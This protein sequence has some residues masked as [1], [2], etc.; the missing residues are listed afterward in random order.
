[1]VDSKKLAVFVT[2][3]LAMAL[4][5]CS[6]EK[7]NRPYVFM[8]GDFLSAEELPYDSPPQII[9]R[10]DDHRFVTLE[11][12]RDCYHG[13]TWYNDTSTGIRK[14]LGR[15]GIEAYQ[16]KLINADPT[17]RNLAFPSAAPP[18]MASIDRG[19]TVGLLYST[20]GG[21]TFNSTS[22]MDNSFDP[23]ADS[24]R[25][26]IIADKNKLY[27][28]KADGDDEAYVVEKPL[29]SD[30]DLNKPYPPG[31]T[32]DSF[33]LSEQPEF[34]TRFRTPSGQ[35]RITCDSSVKPTNP[36]APLG[37]GGP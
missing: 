17:G 6:G 35:D 33:L 16:G 2:A 18:H 13:D 24:K 14:A 20:D 3:F 32:G 11:R 15:G 10:I 9:Y 1:M 31:I 29:M 28:A 30:V 21:K 37:R 23:F 19:W 7:D 36:D 22:Y 5:G 34:L 8:L 4:Y 27:I 12:Y 26:A 25:Y